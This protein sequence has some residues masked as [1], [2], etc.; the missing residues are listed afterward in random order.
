MYGTAL[1]ANGRELYRSDTGD[2]VPLVSDLG[3][4]RA[5]INFGVNV[6]DASVAFLD[7]RFFESQ[8]PHVETV[9]QA[10]HFMG[11]LVAAN[12]A[13]VEVLPRPKTQQE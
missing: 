5:S 13:P 4:E 11:R 7:Q 8:Q 12:M 10:I 9:E 1:D 6:N 3:G 2:I